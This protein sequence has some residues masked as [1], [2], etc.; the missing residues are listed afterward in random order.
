MKNW[1][2]SYPSRISPLT[3]ALF[4]WR[5]ETPA[6]GWDPHRTLPAHCFYEELKNDDD[7][8]TYISARKLIPDAQLYAVNAEAL[9]MKTRLK[10]HPKSYKLAWKIF[11]FKQKVHWKIFPVRI[12]D[13]EQR[14]IGC[15]ETKNRGNPEKMDAIHLIVP[16]YSVFFACVY[17]YQA[18]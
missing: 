7:C 13:H 12:Y 9:I 8:Y 15:A 17:A 5:T 6:R 16:I 3:C 10:K 1:N 11:R 18:I 14:R 2:K 4:L